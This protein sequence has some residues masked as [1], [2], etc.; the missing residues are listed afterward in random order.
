ML[1]WPMARPPQAVPGDQIRPNSPS[2]P[3]GTWGSRQGRNW[4]AL[5]RLFP[6]H[7]V[8]LAGPPSFG[9]ATAFADPQSFFCLGRR[10]GL[11]NLRRRRAAR[12]APPA[13]APSVPQA[14]L[15]GTGPAAV[16][17]PPV[18]FGRQS[19]R[20]AAP[21]FFKSGKRRF[22]DSFFFLPPRLDV[23]GQAPGRYLF[24]FWCLAGA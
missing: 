16:F 4:M 9:Q 21:F 17:F 22:Q 3:A 1:K 5:N 10:G 12:L 7:Q 8:G 24:L 19:G 6:W 13:S 15:P 14:L 11:P 2:H 20:F 23:F 18:F